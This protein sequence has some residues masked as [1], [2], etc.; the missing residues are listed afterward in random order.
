MSIFIAIILLGLIILFHEF[1]HF[2]V[3]KANGVCVVEFSI[4]FGP[5]L[6][7]FRKGDTDY[8]LKI[9]PF[10]GSC[11]MLS[12]D[13]E[14]YELDEEQKEK[15]GHEF[16][17]QSMNLIRKYGKASAFETKSLPARIA[18][19]AAGPIYNFILAFFMSVL[20]LGFMGVDTPTVSEVSHESIAYESGLREGDVITNVAGVGIVFD[21]ELTRELQKHTSDSFD[22][23][24]ERDGVSYTA[25]I[26]PIKKQDNIYKIGAA[27]GEDASISSIE[28]NSPAQKAK[29]KVNDKII[30]INS[31]NVSSSKE[32]IEKIRSSD[33][34]ELT[35]K[36][37]RGGQISDIQIIPNKT[38]STTYDMGFSTSGERI[39]VNPWETI[40]YAFREVWYWITTV[41]ELLGRM[42]TGR[43]SLNSLSG[44][45]GTV[46]AISNV[47]DASS[48]DG[49]FFV[50]MNVLYIGIMLSANLGIMNLLPIPGLDGGRLLLYLIEAIMGRPVPKEKEGIINF[51]GFIFILL[52]TVIVLVK[53]IMR[54]F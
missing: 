29:L 16:V 15:R 43:L 54:L 23:T 13:E 11:R 26:N 2:I 31:E 14:L 4:G 20:M 46:S 37:E 22:I 34:K 47:I 6:F 7:S 9:L 19:I 12:S 38:D 25:K 39:K 8:C 21:R 50:L 48:S 44:P 24:Y 1:G 17:K 42:V 53:D 18:V 35:F 33:G 3:A 51:I 30:Q 32:V 52:L 40:L 28:D 27:L 45:V 10:G 49:A 41:I 5:R 36:I